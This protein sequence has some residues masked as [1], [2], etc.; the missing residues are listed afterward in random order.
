MADP[1][2]SVIVVCLNSPDVRK[3]CLDAL[4]GQS[5]MSNAEVLVVGKSQIGD[6]LP[7]IGDD[8]FPK[9]GLPEVRWLSVSPET[10]V[11]QMRARGILQSRG[12]VVVLIEDD[13]VAPEGWLLGLARA[14]EGESPIIGGAIAP[15]AYRR[16]LDWAVYFCEF[17]RFMP[18]F[19]GAQDA[20]PGNHVSYKKTALTKY[21]FGDGFYEVFFHAAWQSA[22][23]SLTA[24]PN[25][26]IVNINRWSLRHL[27]NV[28]FHHGRAFAAMRSVSF[29]LWRKSLYALLSP[30]LPVVKLFR[31]ASVVIRRRR[32]RLQ[33]LL[34]LLWIMLFLISWSLGEMVGYV[35]GAGS[36]PAQW[37]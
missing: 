29:P 9:N 25:L 30:A 17:A 26:V 31:L 35:A 34:S 27:T 3:A 10:T 21:E 2:F 22:G 8:R 6:E 16:W 4:I 18:P 32:Y 23:G 11:P 37:R 24:D 5:H 15:D 12:E 36:S 20:L 28:P 13:C 19:F 7:G 14:H 1:K 33:F